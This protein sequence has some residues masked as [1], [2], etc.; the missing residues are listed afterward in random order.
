M[1][2][3]YTPIVVTAPTIEPITSAELKAQS[4]I[5]T[6]ADDTLISR[7]ITVARQQC[8][9]IAERILIDTVFDLYA[10]A[11]PA[12]FVLP[13]TPVDSVTA[14]TYTDTDGTTQTVAST[15]YTLDADHIPARVY[16]A[17][18]QSWPTDIRAINKAVKIRWKA[19][20]GTATTDVPEHMRHAVLLLAAH[21]YENREAFTVELLK[22]VPLG[23]R[24][25][26]AIDGRIT[27]D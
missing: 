14:I 4:R 7:I 19:G 13:R 17:F 3:N 11:F 27:V 12:Q 21:Y 24:D 18:E 10:D 5:T 26:L 25:L 8:E 22:Q 23:V 9:L 16:P 1:G 15:V 6:D 20:Y 2:Q